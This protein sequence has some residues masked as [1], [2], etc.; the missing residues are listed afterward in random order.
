MIKDNVIADA[1]AY[2][3]YIAGEAQ[4]SK[5]NTSIEYTGWAFKDSNDL[6]GFS[7]SSELNLFVKYMNMMNL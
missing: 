3:L 6:I 7:D 2:A 5:L 4:A 1:N